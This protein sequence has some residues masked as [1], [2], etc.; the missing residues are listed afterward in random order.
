MISGNPSGVTAGDN[1]D[2]ILDLIRTP[3]G[4]GLGEMVEVL[5]ADGEGDQYWA[6]LCDGKT[7]QIRY[8][9]EASRDAGVKSVF[10]AIYDLGRTYH[11]VGLAPLAAWSD[12]LDL[13]PEDEQ[14]AFEE[15]KGRTIRVEWPA[16]IESLE[17]YG[18]LGQLSGWTITGL[19]RGSNCFKS[20]PGT[21]YRL[22]LSFG[23]V[24]GVRLLYLFNGNLLVASGYRTG[25]GVLPFTEQN[26]SGISGSVSVTYASDLTLGTAYV[27]ARWAASY[28]VHCAQTLTFPRTAET[29][30]KDNGF[31]NSFVALVGPLTA[32]TYLVVV[33]AVNDS[34]VT[35]ANTTTLATVVLPG[36][37]EPPGAITVAADGLSI[38]FPASATVGATYRLYASGLSEPI[39]F[40]APAATHIAGTGTISW[41]LPVWGFSSA[42]ICRIC[43]VAVNGGIEDG[44]Q[45]TAELEFGAGGAYVPPRP[46]APAFYLQSVAGR[47][48]T[49]KYV[50]D[51][52]KEKVAPATV[53]LYAVAEGGSVG[54]PDASAAITAA[55]LNFRSGT[56]IFTVAA[57]GWYSYLVRAA[58]SAGTLSDNVTLQGPVWLSSA[59]P[60]APASASGVILA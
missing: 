2:L 39:D 3:D 53:K 27:V 18:D 5:V 15:D 21:Q 14:F 16:V 19:A 46:N 22:N 58:S 34:G 55:T 4:N 24:A 17:A 52:A 30:V 32:G 33:Q 20:G 56:M 12:T 48:L 42:G 35:G 7:Q 59:A 10:H 60:A 51:S 50:Y 54:S 13:T 8:V 44:Y 11:T 43:V 47:A 57:D 41:T 26:S 29:T 36:R 28:K 25:D 45:R 9:T 31:A 23:N 1:N 37:P 40:Q 49:L 38:S 6:L